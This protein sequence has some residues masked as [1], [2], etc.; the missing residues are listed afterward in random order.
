MNKNNGKMKITKSF[1][2]F[3]TCFIMV[4]IYGFLEGGFYGLLVFLANNLLLF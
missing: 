2:V 3:K 4:V 1:G